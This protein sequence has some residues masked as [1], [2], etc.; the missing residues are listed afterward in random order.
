M[1]KFLPQ[2]GGHS[3]KLDEFQ[4]MQNSYF[5]GFKALVNKLAPSGNVM[6]DGVIVDQSGV[7][8]INTSGYIA[9]AGEIL[10]VEA[11]SFAKSLNPAD[12]LYFK[13]IQTVIAP[14]P[15]TYE[16]TVPKNVHFE[17]KA[18]LKYKDISDT[19]GVLYSDMSFPGVLIE[20]GIIPWYPPTGKVVSDYFDNTGKGINSAI[21]Y[22][23][24]NGL[25]NTLDLRG[26]YLPMTTNVPFTGGVAPLRTI[27]DGITA[28]A[29]TEGGRGLVTLTKAQLPNYTLT[30][31]VT[32]P[33]HYHLTF[34]NSD[35][36]TLGPTTYPTASHGTGGNLG[37]GIQGST[38][39]A[40]FGKSSSVTTGITVTVT[41]GGSGSSHENR[42]PSFYL[43]YVTKIRL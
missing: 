12:L 4:L 2:T 19:D 28:N 30:T 3:L 38:T 27:L 14:S 37:Y 20:G 1:N 25:N 13:P 23:I 21:G 18:I 32:D 42:P 39:V 31:V 10:K 5:E 29:G 41:S 43:Y 9:I 16:D 40:T 35:N 34:G 6:I 36:T 11:N 33:S 22:A 26:M 7:N 24:C 15:V 8:V 17:R